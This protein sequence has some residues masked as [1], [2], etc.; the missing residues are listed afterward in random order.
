MACLTVTSIPLASH[1]FPF[2]FLYIY[3]NIYIYFFPRSLYI[4]FFF[5]FIFVLP[6][7]RWQ[8]RQIR[9]STFY[10]LISLALSLSLCDFGILLKNTHNG[11]NRMEREKMLRW[12]TDPPW[13]FPV[14]HLTLMAFKARGPEYIDMLW[15][16]AKLPYKG[17]YVDPP[18]PSTY[19][20]G[21]T[22]RA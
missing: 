4:Y 10:T 3:T 13:K 2:T 5:C 6:L 14:E 1:P 20:L 19:I 7:P 17:V 22:L 11:N 9:F 12:N 15:C 18:T 16:V 21:H 8:Q